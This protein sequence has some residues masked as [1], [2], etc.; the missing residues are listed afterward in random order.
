[1]ENLLDFGYVPFDMDAMRTLHIRNICE[2]QVLS[3]NNVDIVS[4]SAEFRLLNAPIEPVI[5]SDTHDVLEIDVLYHP[6]DIGTDEGTIAISSNDPDGVAPVRLQSAYKGDVSIEATPNPLTFQDIDI[7]AVAEQRTLIVRNVKN[8][9]ED[10]AVL[11]VNAAY[12]E[13]T[14][15]PVFNLTSTSFPFYLGQGSEKEISIRCQPTEAVEFRNDLII[16]SNDPEE[17]LYR[18]EL[19]C[20]GVAPELS[21]DNVSA[22][23]VLDFG[24]QRLQMETI[25]SLLLRNSGD[26]PLNLFEPTLAAGSHSSFTLDTSAFPAEGRGL[27]PGMTASLPVHF[28]AENEGVYHGQIRLQ[29]DVPGMETLFVDLL[30][31]AQQIALNLDPALLEFGQ[32]R[33]G[34]TLKRTLTIENIGEIPVQILDVSLEN[35]TSTIQF[36][37]DPSMILGDLIPGSQTSITLQFAPASRGNALNTLEFETDDPEHP[38]IQV[39]LSGMGIAPIIQLTERDNPDFTDQLDFGFITLDRQGQR[40]LEIHNLGDAILHILDM[41]LATNTADEE[42]D[43]LQ[44]GV[45][46]VNPN[47]YASVTLTYNPVGFP[48]QDLGQLRIASDDSDSPTM[49]IGLVGTAT[50]QRLSVS[51]LP[52][53]KFDDSFFGASKHEILRLSNTGLLGVLDITGIEVVEGSEVFTVEPLVQELPYTLYPNQGNWLTIEITFSPPSADLQVSPR[54]YA[55]RLRIQSSSYTGELFEDDLEA[56][57]VPCPAGCWDNDGNPDDCEYCGCNLTN[58]GIEI[59][60]DED[61]DCDGV[62]DEPGNTLLDNCSPP[63]NAAAVCLNGAC[64]FVCTDNYHRCGDACYTQDDPAH[65]GESCENCADDGL[66]CTSTVCENE[67]CSHVLHEAACLIDGRCYAYNDDNPSNDCEACL[68]LLSQSGW[69]SKANGSLCDDKQYCTLNSACQFGSCLGG[70][71]RDCWSAVVE[72]QCQEPACDE[73]LDTC[74]ALPIHEGLEC[75]DGNPDTGQDI[76]RDGRCVGEACTCFEINTCCNGCFPRNEGSVCTDDGRTCTD[77]V[78]NSGSC[79]H[80]I[81]DDWCLIDNVCLSNGTVDESNTCRTCDANADSTDWSFRA[82][83]QPC[84]DGQFCLIDETCQSGVCSSDEPRDCSTAVTVPQC[85]SASC[86]EELDQCV[87]LPANEDQTCDDGNPATGGDHCTNGLCLGEGCTC[88]QINACC[89]GCFPINESQSCTD[90]GL[91]CTLDR[92]TE[93]H[94]SHDLSP[95]FCLIDDVC[96]ADGTD[97]PDFPCQYCDALMPDRWRAKPNQT[98]CED[99]A[100]CTI[101]DHCQ[102]GACLADGPRDCSSAV[103]DAQCEQPACNEV[104]DRCETLPRDYG[105]AC[106]DGE[107]CSYDDH[108][109]GFGHCGGTEIVCEN[110]SGTCGAAR[111]CNGSATCET[112]WPGIETSCDD[113]ELCT[114]DDRCDGSGGCH[115]EA[116][117]C[118]DDLTTCGARRS[119]N[120]SSL[121]SIS[122]PGSDQ[123]CNDQNPCSYDDHCNSNGACVGVEIDCTDDP[124]VC[125]VKRSCNGSDICSTF[126]PAGEQSCDDAELCTYDDHCNG[127]GSC[128]GTT[129]TCE[130]DPGDCGVRRDCNGTAVC[131]IVHPGEETSCDDDDLCT[132]SDHC[133]GSGTCVGEPVLC[134]SDPAVCGLK[135]A[136]DAS[137]GACLEHYPDETISCD[138]NDP[139]SPDDHCNAAGECVGTSCPDGYY[140]QDTTCRKEGFIFTPAS[141][142]WMGS[143]E[144]E[145]GREIDETRHYV[146]LTYNL[147]V[148][149]HEVTQEEFSSR[150]GYNPSYFDETCGAQCPVENVSWHEAL[151]YANSFSADTGLPSCFICTGTLPNI[152]CTL[153]STYAKPQDCT[154]FRLPTEAEWEFVA[155]AGTENATPSGNL[156]HTGCDPVDAGLN[157]LGWFCGNATLQPHLGKQKNANA[158]GL[159]DILGNVGEWVWDRYYMNY[160]TDLPTDPIGPGGTASSRVIR[161]GNWQYEARW[162]RLA[163]RA[164]N[165]DSNRF[166]NVGF[167]LVRSISNP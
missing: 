76:C 107:L 132:N 123:S 21:L 161:G 82:D 149:D 104:D 156:I 137:T 112:T 56:T 25:Q 28:L 65:C 11:R 2:N 97:R 148:M 71:D 46:A 142:F 157:S 47:S 12:L 1:M 5:L 17:P 89:D 128:I 145:L 9:E 154:G 164:A 13:S 72:T 84:D 115:G 119:C 75:N 140:C 122:F 146:T 60:D 83:G 134:T 111:A 35:E 33:V 105:I 30:G 70:E 138:D 3:I 162:C 159:Y 147:E 153:D 99:G 31:E 15:S 143:R 52:P 130:D 126:Y 127:S 36:D 39:P 49:I 26:A 102:D 118:T 114:Y 109:D 43:I 4:D 58:G 121:C 19:I 29:S 40:H 7:T 69:S 88:S 80:S 8:G 103:G 96:I 144:E 73:E 129:I 160:Q 81:L 151:A 34:Q 93:G 92:C 155:R 117:I 74:L 120:G 139:C 163:S 44:T 32:V 66:T 23:F 61:N 77:D 167:R 45:V 18:V 90:D 85:Q 59:C 22:D 42:F 68:P 94:C 55:G 125:G 95:G 166:N 51:P 100:F 79:E 14:D 87:A 37:G 150:M 10:N 106:N 108:C 63:Q 38:I 124:S 54:D 50:D 165:T 91:A 152:T 16:E 27:N 116:V 98:S 41:E 67:S 101:G 131:S 53:W 113:G 64:D 24:T 110:D 86:N 78:C 57:A 48:G 141:S 6:T 135:S 136:C 133:N 20:N 158:W 62:T